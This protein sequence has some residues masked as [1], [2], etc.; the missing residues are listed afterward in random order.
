MDALKFRITRR[1]DFDRL[2]SADPSTLTDLERAARFLYL[3]RLAF[4]GKVSGRNFGVDYTRGARFNVN[5]L[6][7]V[8]TEV[9]ERLAGR[10][11]RKSAMGGGF[12]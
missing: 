6:G 4:G 8:L 10:M 5:L 11:S 2:S 7:P 1:A 3:Q 9:H 12:N